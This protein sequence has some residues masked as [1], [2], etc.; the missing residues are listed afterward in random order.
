MG[1]VKPRQKNLKKSGKK[2]P[3]ETSEKKR[4]RKQKKRPPETK[5][6]KIFFDFFILFASDF[7]A[8]FVDFF[9]FIFEISLSEIF[10]AA[11]FLANAFQH[12]PRF[13]ARGQRNEVAKLRH[14]PQAER[15]HDGDVLDKQEEIRSALDSG[16]I[17]CFFLGE[18]DA[19][20][21]ADEHADAHLEGMSNFIE[22]GNFFFFLEVSG[23]QWIHAP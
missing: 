13:S 11:N 4:F 23:A 20:E 21:K 2:C 17:L 9:W 6:R 16:G 5:D 18:R 10:N 14:R 3:L 7:L 12:R 15:H 8:V 22:G 19:G 1:C